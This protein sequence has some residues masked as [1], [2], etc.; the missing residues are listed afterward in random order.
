MKHVIIVGHPG[1]G[2]F[3][4]SIARTYA[5]AVAA[6]GHQAVTRDL[7]WMGFDPRLTAEERPD[8]GVPVVPPEVAKERAE[9]KG[10]DVIVFVYPIWY[11]MPPAIVVGYIDRVFGEGFAYEGFH[12][13]R[14]SPLLAGKKMISFTSSGSTTAWLGE[15]GVRLSLESVLNDY[16]GGLWGVDVIDHV[17]F[18]SIVPDLNQRWVLEHL[19]TVEARVTR[20]FGSL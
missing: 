11:G 4:L 12:A 6:L 20:H 5:N 9:L 8:T 13:G 15:R 10:A 18:P 16:L 2:S 19:N 7:Y 3:T 1:E 14:S 17:H